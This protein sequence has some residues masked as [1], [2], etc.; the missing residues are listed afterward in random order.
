VLSYE[1]DGSILILRA[2]GTSTAD[3]RGSAL[4]TVRADE[5]VPTGALLLLDAR[6]V[7]VDASK[8]AMVER[9]HMLLHHLG[10]K[11]GHVCAVLAAPRVRDQA[12]IFKAAAVGIGLRAEIFSDE[13]SARRWLNANSRRG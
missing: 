2:S 10:P 5:R 7:D 8:E 6:E 9:L 1:A 3:E 13:P 4:D 11:L 12:G